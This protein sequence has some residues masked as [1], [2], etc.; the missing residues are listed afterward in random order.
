MNMSERSQQCCAFD[1]NLHDPYRTAW[2][3]GEKVALAQ[4]LRKGRPAENQC[5]PPLGRAGLFLQLPFKKLDFLRKRIVGG[6]QVL[7]FSYRMQD[8]GMVPAPEAPSD[9]GQRT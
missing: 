9:L 5:Y 1:G 2:E 8:G 4:G 7:D 3:R 6:D